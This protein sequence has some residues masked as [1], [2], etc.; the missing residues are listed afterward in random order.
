MIGPNSNRL[1]VLCGAKTRRP[2]KDQLRLGLRCGAL[3]RL[4]AFRVALVLRAQPQYPRPRAS[5]PSFGSGPSA[6]ASR[7]LPECMRAWK[8]GGP[9]C[10]LSRTTSSV[11]NCVPG[12]NSSIDIIDTDVFIDNCTKKLRK[13]LIPLVGCLQLLS[14]KSVSLVCI[15][16]MIKKI[17][18]LSTPYCRPEVRSSEN[19]VFHFIREKSAAQRKSCFPFSKSTI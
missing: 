6:L 4:G 17:F 19:M 10:S 11:K 1:E 12:I 13:P 5:P 14:A 2:R 16:S 7:W 3:A 9:C 8:L 18:L 15:I